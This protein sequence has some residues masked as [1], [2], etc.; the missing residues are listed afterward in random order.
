MNMGLYT[1]GKA[2]K[3]KRYCNDSGL[4]VCGYVA[5]GVWVER[6]P[7]GLPRILDPADDAKRTCGPG[8]GET[9]GRESRKNR[10]RRHGRSA[11]CRLVVK[12]RD[13]RRRNIISRASQ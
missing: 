11:R 2:W 13:L 3:S 4:H 5:C 8:G 12:F 10:V 1:F 7:G 9:G 6:R